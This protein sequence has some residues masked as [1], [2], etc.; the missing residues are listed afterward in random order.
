MTQGVCMKNSSDSGSHT[1]DAQPLVLSGCTY[2]EINFQG[3]S[4][5][6]NLVALGCTAQALVRGLRI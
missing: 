6:Q 1:E 4:K 5:W 3:F 2:F